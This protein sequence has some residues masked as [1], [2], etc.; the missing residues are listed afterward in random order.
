MRYTLMLSMLLA[1]NAHA[2]S[3]TGSR[4]LDSARAYLAFQADNDQD[5]PVL[6]E[7]RYWQGLVQGAS[8]VFAQ[9]SYKYALCYPEE[10][11]LGQTATLAAQHLIENPDRLNEPVEDLIWASHFAAYGFM[12]DR[13]CRNESRYRE[14]HDK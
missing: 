4:A 10:S 3:V 9:P 14:I 5:F 8:S 1:V 6:L 11:N 12:F 2:Y 13:T 7:V